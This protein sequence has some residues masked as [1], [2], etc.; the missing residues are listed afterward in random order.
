MWILFFGK[1]YIASEY[2]MDRNYIVFFMYLYENL[3]AFLG[4]HQGVA[5]T[6]YQISY[7]SFQQ[8]LSKESMICHVCI[9]ENR[10]HTSLQQYI[11]P[12]K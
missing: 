8:I 9:M 5:M 10:L 4:M 7:F 1:D 6:L 12:P 3:E 11:P 2:L